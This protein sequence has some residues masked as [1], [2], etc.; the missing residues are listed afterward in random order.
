[1]QQFLEHLMLPQQRRRDLTVLLDPDFAAH[2]GQ[3]RRIIVVHLRVQLR[4]VPRHHREQLMP[5]V[6]ELQEVRLNFRSIKRF[7]LPKGAI[8]LS[9]TRLV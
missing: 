9:P 5:Q 3:Q 8:P 6:H 4:V 2:Q 1:M 7:S